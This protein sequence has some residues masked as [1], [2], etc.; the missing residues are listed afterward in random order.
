[1]NYKQ[2][3]IVVMAA[4]A[5]TTANAQTGKEWDDPLTTSINRET[6]HTLAIPAASEADVA[7]N[8]LTL[9]PYYQSLDGKWKFQWVGIPSKALA[10][11]CAKDFNDASWTDIDVPSSWQVWGLNHNKS[12]D[13]PL[14]SNTQY[15]FEY[16]R[17][18]FSV[19]ADRPSWFTYKDNM[20]NPVGTYRR[21]FTIPESW[22][23]RDV[24]VRFNSVGHGYYLWVNGERI[25]Y[26]ED[27]YL[28]SEFNITKYLVEGEN[29]IALQVYRFTSGSFLECQDYWRLTGI[30]R[31]CFLW[32]APKSQIRDYFFTTDLDSNYKNAKA[33]VKVWLTGTEA[34]KDGTV[35]VKIMSDGTAI[36]EQTAAAA[37]ELSLDMDVTAP[38]LWS[39]E[40]PNLYDLVLTLKD[41]DGHVLDIRGSKVGF[42]EVGIR[43]D[44]ALLINGQRM[45][46][47]GVNRHDFSPVNGRAITPEEIEGDI[48]TMKRL[49]INAIR[50]S[51]YPN[52]PVFYD[53]CDKY[54]MYV[55]A[56][57]DVECH[58][59]WSLSSEPKFKNAMVERSQNHVRWMRNHVCIFMWSFGNECGGGNN[60]Q[61]VASA[62]KAL[63]KTRLTHYEGNSDYA[64][65]SSTMYGRGED[66]AEAP[67]T[68]REFPLHGQLH[69]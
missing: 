46:F 69:G 3:L 62:V 6:A 14:Y 51:H 64:D 61:A 15:P 7:K 63:D 49:N 26:S 28:P 29:T 59:N 4:L 17:S 43:S 45:V 65:V 1:M 38:K 13:K 12:W 33:N 55:L 8:D 36:A 42:R 27:S 54:G 66:G 16:D 21:T 57:A 37:A 2:K 10:S 11:W 9:S 23:D 56:E 34:V 32:A 30:H 52:D 53:L 24:Y 67:H 31:S 25:G 44:G 22:K 60:F 41:Q 48:K 50:T 58:G 18:T 5:A 35:E 68:M 40:T 47:H 19:M 39:A 20:A